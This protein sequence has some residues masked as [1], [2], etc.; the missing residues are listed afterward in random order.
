MMQ[1]QSDVHCI[2]ALVEHIYGPHN[3]PAIALSLAP[4]A[5]NIDL[6]A[7]N[8]AV[9][10]LAD[11]FESLSR[12][13]AAIPS[14]EPAAVEPVADI[15]DRLSNE[16]LFNIPKGDDD[17]M[18]C[19]HEQLD[20]WDYWHADVSVEEAQTACLEP[21]AAVVAVGSLAHS[22]PEAWADMDS[23]GTSDIVE[24]FAAP[25]ALPRPPDL[26]QAKQRKEKQSNAK[27]SKAKQ[28][29]AKQSKA[30]QSKAT[31]NK[32]KQDKAK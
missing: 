29:K 31:Q 12:A 32:S 16:Q 28:S 7:L 13:L 26:Q 9:D 25:G 2:E 30:K 5:L 18:V 24:E 22:A 15:V 19:T 14:S 3:S 17:D 6:G 1:S 23:D 27:Q 10:A 4:D 20:S 21:R 11:R 8:S